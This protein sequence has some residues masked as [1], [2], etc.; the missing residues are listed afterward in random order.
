M[1]PDDGSGAQVMCSTANQSAGSL[2]SSDLGEM[3][4]KKEIMPHA[5]RSTDC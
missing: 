4:V 3:L 5:C 2:S 1:I